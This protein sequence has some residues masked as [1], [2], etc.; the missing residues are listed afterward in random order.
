MSS[1]MN[2]EEAKIVASKMS[3]SQAVSNA[4]AAKCVPYRKATKLK[5]KELLSIAP[6]M[7]ALDI[8]YD[9]YGPEEGYPYCPSCNYC[10]KDEL[11]N[12]HYC[13][14]CGQKVEWNR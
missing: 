8:V 1:G 7:D 13:P 5:L 4:L 3:Y 11:V 2:L 12:M 9:E 6:K 14:N 10:M